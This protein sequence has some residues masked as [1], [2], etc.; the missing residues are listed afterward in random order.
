MFL[1]MCSPFYDYKHNTDFKK[2]QKLRKEKNK[3]Y[4]IISIKRGLVELGLSPIFMF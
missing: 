1:D 3:M 4:L 2:K